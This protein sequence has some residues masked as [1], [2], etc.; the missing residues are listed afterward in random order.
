MATPNGWRPPAELP[1]VAFI[2]RSNAGKSSLLNR[3][4]RRSALA[5]VSKT[6]GRTR[7]INFFRVNDRFVLADL[8]GYGYAR[9]PREQR[10]NWRPLVE[11]YLR[12]SATLRGV[13]QVLDVRRDP[14]AEDFRVR[15]LL[16]DIGV[17]VL[18]VATKTDTLG[19]RAAQDRLAAIAAAL[20]VEQDG[21]VAVS[22]RTGEGRD[23]L[24]LAIL[25][26]LDAGT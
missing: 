20:A 7:E 10:A 11:S 22:N 18:V 1:E 19:A 24:A 17:P 16:A 12:H 25:A 2:G 8:P 9:L 26:L 13:V 23:E 5:R 14:T 4:V 21:V 15:D 3:L 6:P